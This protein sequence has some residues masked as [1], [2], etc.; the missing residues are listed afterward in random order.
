VVLS[1][2]TLQSQLRRHFFILLNVTLYF[3][4]LGK[5]AISNIS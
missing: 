4:F 3:I 2:S 1:Q 5:T